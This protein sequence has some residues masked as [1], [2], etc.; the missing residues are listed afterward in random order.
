MLAQN[1]RV[2]FQTLKHSWESLLVL[3]GVILLYLLPRWEWLRAWLVRVLLPLL[4]EEGRR[5][6]KVKKLKLSVKG[7]KLL[8]VQLELNGKGNI[9]MLELREKEKTEA[10]EE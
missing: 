8:S 4:A 3:L 1:C 10:L 9:N 7:E 6:Q 5:N 2:C